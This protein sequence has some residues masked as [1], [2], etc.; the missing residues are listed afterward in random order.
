MLDLKLLTTFREVALRGSFSDA[1]TGATLDLLRERAG[2]LAGHPT[3]SRASHAAGL[4][5][6]LFPASS[7]PPFPRA[8]RS[9]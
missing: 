7:R 8:S 3:A 2:H 6:G 9:S 1:A 4:L 5:R